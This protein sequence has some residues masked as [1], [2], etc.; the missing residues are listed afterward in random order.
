MAT[1]LAAFLWSVCWLAFHVL[2]SWESDKLA[3][4]NTT[5]TI[6]VAVA[7]VVFFF[8]SFV[9]S[10]SFTLNSLWV[11]ATK[12]R[13]RISLAT[14]PLLQTIYLHLLRRPLVM[15]VS[16]LSRLAK[17]RQLPPHL[18]LASLLAANQLASTP[19]SPT[20]LKVG[21][22]ANSQPVSHQAK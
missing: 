12:R 16:V 15:L 9:I 3:G 13:P 18:Q 5:A 20:L 6:V 21:T 22:Q 4:Y 2:A 8:V 19:L 17:E 10:V 7:V 1:S 14:S 11:S